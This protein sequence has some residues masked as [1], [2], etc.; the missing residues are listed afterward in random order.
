MFPSLRHQHPS[1]DALQNQIVTVS[2]G[3]CNSL[4]W[5]NKKWSL[6]IKE[7]LKMLGEFSSNS[8]KGKWCSKSK[9]EHL[10]SKSRRI[11]TC[12]SFSKKVTI[13]FKYGGIRLQRRK[14]TTNPSPLFVSPQFTC[15]WNST[16]EQPD[17]RRHC[18]EV[19]EKLSWKG[20]MYCRHRTPKKIVRAA[21]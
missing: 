6:P 17:R 16:K 1:T 2:P 9:V 18:L 20:R 5:K 19:K 4:A 7:K 10:Q 13:S 14:T 21:V 8:N 12:K 3:N 15:H 11:P